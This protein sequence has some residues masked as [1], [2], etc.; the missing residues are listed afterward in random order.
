MCVWRSDSWGGQGGAFVP[1]SSPAV[2]NF[3]DSKNVSH[4]FTAQALNV[5]IFSF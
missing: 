2:G 3:A 4:G 1:R 5:E